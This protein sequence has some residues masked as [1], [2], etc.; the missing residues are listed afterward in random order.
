VEAG[1]VAFD[2]S[3]KPWRRRWGRYFYAYVQTVGPTVEHGYHGCLAVEEDGVDASVL[4]YTL[5]YDE[6]GLNPA[7]RDDGRSQL[8][9][10][11]QGRLQAMSVYVDSASETHP[12]FSDH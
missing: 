5:V 6:R 8:T 12:Q 10:R 1:W 9:R 4:V 2:A 11:F 3:T 7:V